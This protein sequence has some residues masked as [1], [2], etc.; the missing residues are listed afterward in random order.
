M[1]DMTWNSTMEPDAETR[2]V[3]ARDGYVMS[4]RRYHAEGTPRGAIACI[5][6]IQ[7]HAGWYER[8]CKQFAAAGYETFFLDRRGS[9]QNPDDRGDC[10]SNYQLRSDV[11]G[12]VELV[13]RHSF[14]LPLTLLSISW[15]G[16]LALAAVKDRPQLVDALVFLCPG[17]FPKVGPSLREKIGIGLSY[18]V[19]PGRRFDIP[20]SDPKL[21]T[22]SSR[23]QEF[24]AQ[25]PLSLRQ[26]TSRLL[27]A[28][29]VLDVANRRAPATVTAPS[30]LVLAGQDR[31]IDNQRTRQFFNRFESLSKHVLEYPEAHHTL[32][33][34]PEPEP[35]F[36]D[37]LHWLGNL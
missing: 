11:R 13:R 2:T 37:V 1:V 25:D 22:A 23:W 24:I 8:S 17:W 16:K 26:A 31:I 9:G 6:G 27:V 34:E 29:V 5:H 7:S 14:G 28:S 4:Y 20:L 35:I 33:F 10:P 3:K 15:G 36:A 32:E 19:A 12:F 21:F 18:V 30:L